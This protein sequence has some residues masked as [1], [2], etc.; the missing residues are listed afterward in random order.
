M[1]PSTN[2]GM[3]LGLKFQPFAGAQAR[4]AAWQQDAEN[5]VS[6][7]PATGTTVILGKTRRRGVD[8]QLSMQLGDDWTV[9]ASHAYQEA[10][11]TRDDR[12]AGVS[13]QGRQVAATAPHQQSGRGLPRR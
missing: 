12:D 3:E 13:L 9:W 4:L 6:N 8:A 5:E 11:I 2:T 1:Q 10:K 7:M